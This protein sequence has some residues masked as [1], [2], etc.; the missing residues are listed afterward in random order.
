MTFGPDVK[1]VQ[2]ADQK[3]GGAIHLEPTKPEPGAGMAVVSKLPKLKEGRPAPLMPKLMG[4]DKLGGAIRDDVRQVDVYTPKLDFKRILRDA[5]YL[6][7]P[8]RPKTYLHGVID[9]IPRD[10]IAYYQY[11]PVYTGEEEFHRSLIGA[12]SGRGASADHPTVQKAVYE[13][14]KHRPE[15][16]AT[17]MNA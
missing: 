9:M 11:G 5:A 12:V 8:P 7:G 2:R 1:I 13:S 15:L 4:E 6:S 16:L 10:Q 3:V 17:Y 14:L